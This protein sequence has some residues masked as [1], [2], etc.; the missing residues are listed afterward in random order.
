MKDLQF[1][2]AFIM[3]VF[4]GLAM[5]TTLQEPTV[6]TFIFFVISADN[7]TTVFKLDKKK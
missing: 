5:A 7:L 1:Y 3:F 6:F 2:T 4:F